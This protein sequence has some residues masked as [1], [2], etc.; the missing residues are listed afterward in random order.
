M[1]DDPVPP[2]HISTKRNGAA[3]GL[4]SRALSWAQ[5]Q[6]LGDP[7]YVVKG[8]IDKGAF[9]EIYGAFGSGKSFLVGDPGLRVALGWSWFDRRVNQ[10]GVLYI[11]VEGGTNIKRRLAAF[12]KHHEVDLDAVP[13]RVVLDPTNMLTPAG[14]EQLI[15]DAA[16]VPDLTLII[17]DTAAR[18]MPGGKEDT[19]DMGKFVSACDEVRSK[20]GAAVVVVHHSGKTAERG[21]R[22]SVVLPAAVDAMLEVTVDE[23]SKV[24]TAQL[25]KSRDGATGANYEFCLEVVLLGQDVDGDRLTSK[26]TV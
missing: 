11:A 23:K 6:G 4:R 13:F 5:L 2:Q 7:A 14:I 8:I 9:V 25:V 26:L 1:P 24:S 18:V 22:G 12:A 19:E 17:I 21:S 3:G 20:T 16:P 10:G 15:T